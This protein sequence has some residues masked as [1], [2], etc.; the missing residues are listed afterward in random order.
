MGMN[1]FGGFYSQARRVKDYGIAITV[2]HDFT[3]YLT[4]MNC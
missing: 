4:Q 1:C 3:K 2:D